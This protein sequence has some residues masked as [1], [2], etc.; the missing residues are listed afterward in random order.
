MKRPSGDQAGERSLASLELVRLRTSPLSAGTVTISP[1]YSKT[2]RAP[3][4]DTVPERIQRAPSTH[5]G[6]RSIRSAATPS[7]SLRPV[8]SAPPGSHRYSQ[9]ACS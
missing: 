7:R 3:L 6:R 5:R 8:R 4:G 9:P 1:R 2:T